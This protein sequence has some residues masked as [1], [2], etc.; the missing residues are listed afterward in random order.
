VDE[1]HVPPWLVRMDREIFP[2]RDVD[3]VRS[4]GWGGTVVVM[5]L[6]EQLPPPSGEDTSA[7]VCRGGDSSPPPSAVASPQSNTLKGG[8]GATAWILCPTEL[9]GVA[10]PTKGEPE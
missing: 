10:K 6:L 3:V 7:R 9:R 5:P 2:H 8:G 1:P 4:C